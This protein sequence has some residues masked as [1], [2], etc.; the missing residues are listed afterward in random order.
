MRFALRWCLWLLGGLLGLAGVAAAPAPLSDAEW[1]ALFEADFSVHPAKANDPD[2]AAFLAEM[3]ER[4]VKNEQAEWFK[5]RAGRFLP[6]EKEKEMWALHGEA[7]GVYHGKHDREEGLRLFKNIEALGWELQSTRWLALGYWKQAQ[8]W[9]D[10]GE[11]LHGT[12]LFEQARRMMEMNGNYRGGGGYMILLGNLFINYRSLGLLG[13]ALQV[14]RALENAAMQNLAKST[15]APVPGLLVDFTDE[16]LA[17]VPLE[18]IGNYYVAEVAL[19]YEAGDDAGALELAEKLDRRLTGTTIPREVS[20]HAET[21]EQI[22]KVHEAAG[23]D[24]ECEATLVRLLAVADAPKAETKDELNLGRIRLAWLRLRLGDDPATQFSEAQAGLDGLAERLWLRSWLDGRGLLARM[25]AHNGDLPRGLE[26][27]DAAIDQARAIRTPPLLA[28][29]LLTRAELRL[30]AG[31]TEGVQD[32]LFEA[33]TNYR[34]MG[35]LRDETKAYVQYARFLR[36]NGQTADAARMLA[37]ATARLK[38]FPQAWQRTVMEREAAALAIKFPPISIPDTA[39]ADAGDVFSSRWLKIAPDSRSRGQAP[40]TV[41]N[42]AQPVKPDRATHES[43]L[44]PIELTTRVAGD[45]SARGRFTLTNPGDVPVSGVLIARGATLDATWDAARLHWSLVRRK[46][47][48]MHEVRQSVVLQPMDQ[49]TVMLTAEAAPDATGNVQLTW[50]RAGEPQTAWWRYTHGG[51]VPDIAV[52]DANLALE[53][54][55]YSVPLHHFV[56]RSDRQRGDLLNLRVVTSEPSRVELV[57]AATSRV[58]AVDATGNGDFRGIGDI[59]FDDKDRDGFPDIGFEK[60]QAARAVEIQVYP[61]AGYKLVAVNL[62]LRDPDG[63]WVT[64]SIDRLLGK[65]Q[66]D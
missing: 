19:R 41:A 29:L 18:F 61:L 57:D 34:Q 22:A 7:S 6:R 37:E 59:L 20:R 23:R 56:V 55:F 5:T 44:Q 14:H 65:N 32:D 8:V 28:S 49:A 1:I 47:G 30:D 66:S 35:G 26:I 3:K 13:E 62:E 16:E 45:W 27:I 42:P 24:R 58:I 54:P 15:G 40:V 11:M 21:L 33:V 52:V 36:I 10:Q 2:H 48:G 17:S 4:Q 46:N 39:N 25:H 60:G 31:S 53:N 12:Y 43:D 9:G 38:R 50:E 63:T 51:G 64:G